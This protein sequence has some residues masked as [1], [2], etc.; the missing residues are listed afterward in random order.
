M[1][2][3]GGGTTVYVQGLS[4]GTD[5]N[6]LQLAMSSALV[7]KHLLLCFVLIYIYCDLSMVEVQW[8]RSP[9]GAEAGEGGMDG[10]MDGREGQLVLTGSC[11]IIRFYLL[12]LPQIPN[13]SY[14]SSKY[15]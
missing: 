6:A 3:I 15:F 7:N 14:C 9:P 12:L 2:T 13:N 10:R 4:S 11:Q 8:R 1:L 5:T